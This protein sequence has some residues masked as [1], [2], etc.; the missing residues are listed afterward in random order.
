MRTAP[1]A[2]VLAACLTHATASRDA[3]RYP[4]AVRAGTPP[5]LA[6]VDDDGRE[7]EI[8][9]RPDLR[10]TLH[11]AHGDLETR[12][13]DLRLTDR[14]LLVDRRDGERRIPWAHLRSVEV[15]EPRPWLVFGAALGASALATTAILLGE[16]DL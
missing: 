15:S 5:V 12:A 14:S 1:L 3:L 13:R 9:V 8:E 4:R 6:A 2:L 11:L 7:I 16:S 10:L